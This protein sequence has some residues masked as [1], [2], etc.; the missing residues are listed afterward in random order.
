M[1]ELRFE[2]L[3]K[4]ESAFLLSLIKHV[5]CLYCPDYHLGCRGG[6]VASQMMNM[7]A[8]EYIERQIPG[9]EA[10]LCGKLRN[11]VLAE[12]SKLI[13]AK[14]QFENM[15]KSDIGYL[16]KEDDRCVVNNINI[17]TLKNSLEVEYQRQMARI[18]QETNKKLS[19]YQMDI[20]CE[21]EGQLK[22]LQLIVLELKSKLGYAG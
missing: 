19:Q 4:A 5:D 22:E 12:D 14:K 3:D 6:Y 13:E 18:I 16:T 9:T 7:P 17:D 20:R 15:L 2:Y 11:I 1:N 8:R 10:F 21:Y